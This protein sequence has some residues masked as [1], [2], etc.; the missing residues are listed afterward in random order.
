MENIN[1]YWMTFSPSR[2]FPFGKITVD[3]KYRAIKNPRREAIALGCH[4]LLHW[5]EWIIIYHLNAVKWNAEGKDVE[6]RANKIQDIILS[7]LF[8]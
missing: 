2:Y 5:A 4:E 7:L 8:L 3:P 1:G 6:R